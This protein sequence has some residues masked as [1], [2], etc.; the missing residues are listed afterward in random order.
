[1]AGAAQWGAR[2][3]ALLASFAGLAAAA[4]VLPFAA[5][6]GAVAETGRKLASRER[7]TGPD[8][9]RLDRPDSAARA[10]KRCDLPVLRGITLIRAARIE[11]ALADGDLT[12][13]DAVRGDLAAT[14]RS[15]LR[16]MPREGVAWF[17]LAWLETAREGATP[18]ALR[19]LAMSY[20][21]APLE[22]WVAFA[23]IDMALKH[24]SAVDE[25][26]RAAIVREWR[27]LLTGGFESF[28]AQTFARAAAEAQDA[29]I[30][31]VADVSPPS[32]RWFLRHLD[33][34]GATERLPPQFVDRERPW[35]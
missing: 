6:D 18:H 19:L 9:A 33:N 23:R 16:C 4:S 32:L 24:I 17:V 27:G 22:A 31:A 8:L 11:L 29:L 1:M 2:L 13:A 26:T 14:A 35:R 34:L 5:R 3:I 21:Q 25:A 10:A 20:R 15:L 12:V 7:F 30:L 28:A